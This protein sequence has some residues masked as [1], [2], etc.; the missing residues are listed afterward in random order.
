MCG[1]NNR[2]HTDNKKRRSS[3]ALFFV[4]GDADAFVRPSVGRTHPRIPSA[5][6]P[7][8]GRTSG[9]HGGGLA[10][11]AHDGWW[12]ES[13]PL[14]WPTEQ[15]LLGGPGG[16]LYDGGVILEVGRRNLSPCIW[17][18]S[19]RKFSSSRNFCGCASLVTVMAR[20]PPNP[21]MEATDWTV[22]SCVWKSFLV[23]A[24]NPSCQSRFKH[25]RFTEHEHQFYN[26]L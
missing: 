1:P 20:R 21:W 26:Q 23:S 2:M 24:I 5:V 3:L 12:L 14:A 19:R 22:K 6:S 17:F 7:A 11:C 18:F 8:D 25:T 9:L 16:S 10:R 4:A 15:L 13:V